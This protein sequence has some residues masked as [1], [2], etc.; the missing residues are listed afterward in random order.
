MKTVISEIINALSSDGGVVGALASNTETGG[1]AIYTE[2]AERMESPYAV[3]TFGPVVENHDTQ[4]EIVLQVDI[5]ERRA[6]DRRSLA[7]I[8]DA[9]AEIIR[10]L[11][12]FTSSEGARNIRVFYTGENTQAPDDGRFRRVSIDFEVRYNR[13][14]TI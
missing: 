13:P 5:Y 10:A 3:L 9:R 14:V 12:R 7:A 4:G 8:L 2:T 6:A 1:P 11:D